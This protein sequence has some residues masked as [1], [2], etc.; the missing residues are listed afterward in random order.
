LV[1]LFSGLS[2]HFWVHLHVVNALGDEL[3]VE[4]FFALLSVLGLFGLLRVLLGAALDR[5]S[6]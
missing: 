6:N 5:L 4:V 2:N 3:V 1:E